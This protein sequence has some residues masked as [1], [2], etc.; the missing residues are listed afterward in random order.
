MSAE[1]RP[2]IA[3]DAAVVLVTDTVPA[4]GPGDVLVRPAFPVV[5]PG[6]E[7]SIIRAS[8]ISADAAHEYPRHGFT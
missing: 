4:L 1:T 5:S 3:R 7:R 8:A 6:T 2:V